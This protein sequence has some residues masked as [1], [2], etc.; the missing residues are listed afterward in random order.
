MKKLIIILVMLMPFSIF[1]QDAPG[2]E[3][4]G[5]R[6]P[7]VAGTFYPSDPDVLRDMID[8]LLHTQVPGRYGYMDITG[9]VAPHA[10]YV[11]SGGVAAAAY[12]EVKGKDYDVAIIIA[13]S[14][15][16]SFR[17]ASVFNGDAYVT[18]LG[19]VM[20]DKELAKTIAAYNDRILYSNKGHKWKGVTPEHSLEVQLPFLQ[21]VLPETKI[22]PI[23]MGS[24]DLQTEDI[25]MRAIVSALSETEK[26]YLIIASTDLSHFH[27]ADTAET[28][29][30]NLVRTFIRYDYFALQNLLAMGEI[31]ACG[32]GPLVTMMMATE[33]LGATHA[34]PVTYLHSGKTE[35]GKSRQ[36]R[37]VGYFSGVIIKG[38]YKEI[39]TPELTYNNKLRLLDKVKEVV[40]NTARG[41]DTTFFFGMVPMDLAQYAPAFVTLKEH[42]QLRACM[43]HTFANNPLILEVQEAAKLAATSDYRFG[44]IKESEL[45]SLHYEITVMSRMRRI[46]DFDEI[47]IGKD[48]LFIR[49]GSNRGLLLPQVASERNWDVKTFL[50]NL[51]LKAG[52]QKEEYKNPLA[53]I[54]AF[55]AL[56]IDEKNLD[57]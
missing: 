20:V 27:S 56:I 39:K 37:V 6:P 7:T 17:G 34:S 49:L 36:D 32:G 52:L 48:G 44:A 33:Q 3:D 55:R 10:G 23:V 45:D 38:K 57:D 40:S 41:K 50:E 12:K 1:S 29:D 19:N 9:L 16:E 13:P 43:G 5:Y 24:Q 11:F 54:Y 47:E 51:C 25:L 2:E 14:H 30:K 31:E 18:P 4:I 28:M 22:V 21:V 42:G 46:L 53:Q 35:A 8:S 15:H 26:K